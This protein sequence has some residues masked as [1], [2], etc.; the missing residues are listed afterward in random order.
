M[1]SAKKSGAPT[2]ILCLGVALIPAILKDVSPMRRRGDNFDT[3]DDSCPGTGAR[4]CCRR[5]PVSPL[6][7]KVIDGG[8]SVAPPF[9]MTGIARLKNWIVG[10]AALFF[11]VPGPLC[12]RDISGVALPEAVSVNGREL[13]LNGTGVGKE[14]MLFDVYVIGLYLETK[15]SDAG[16][17]IKADEGKR[18]VLTMLRDVSRERFV[19]S[20]E[21]CMVRNSASFIGTLRSRLDALEQACPSLLRPLVRQLFWQ[22]RCSS[23]TREAKPG[24][25]LI[26]VRGIECKPVFGGPDNVAQLV[27][28]FRPPKRANHP[29]K[30]ARHLRI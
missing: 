6:F 4:L 5:M 20:V 2:R 9:F 16:A 21:K 22:P 29:A 17:A 1:K 26:Q 7:G 8:D 12:A 10:A 25:S 28:P 19:Q 15:T 30:C 18:I 3:R 24:A 11:T 13:N 27:W 23:T 14:K